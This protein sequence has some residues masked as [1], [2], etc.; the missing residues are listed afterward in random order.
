[1]I[2]YERFDVHMSQQKQK[3]CNLGEEKHD[4]QNFISI[5]ISKRQ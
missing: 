3:I 5:N 2:N 4:F 1:M